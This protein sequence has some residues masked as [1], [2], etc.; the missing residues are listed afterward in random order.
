MAFLSFPALAPNLVYTLINSE[1][2]AW[3][4][5]LQIIPDCKPL[6]SEL[7]S[8]NGLHLRPEP[9]SAPLHSFSFKDRLSNRASVLL[10]NSITDPVY[11]WERGGA[12]S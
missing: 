9:V 1:K 4:Y 7:M 6:K 3:F 5:W 11:R 10:K 2:E 12:E 8:L